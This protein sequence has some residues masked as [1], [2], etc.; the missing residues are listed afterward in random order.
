MRWRQTHNTWYLGGAMILVTSSKV[1]R[2]LYLKFVGIVTADE[3]RRRVVEVQSLM[4]EFKSGFRLLSDLEDLKSMEEECVPILGDMMD[5]FKTKGIEMVVRV[6]P[7]TTKDI[8]LNILSIFHYG[9]NVRTITCE[10]TVEGIKALGIQ[11]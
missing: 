8:G 7:D 6:I 5:R 9:R 11:D 3:M 2:L 4:D 1:H 10:T